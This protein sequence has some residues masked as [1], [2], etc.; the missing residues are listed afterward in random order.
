MGDGILVSAVYCI[1]LIELCSCVKQVVARLSRSSVYL[2]IL[3]VDVSCGWVVLAVDAQPQAVHLLEKQL[4][5]RQ[6]CL[7][8]ITVLQLGEL[9]YVDAPGVVSST[10][11]GAES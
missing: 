4:R 6:R 9:A 2:A 7:Q 10:R 5:V 8:V 3:L 11:A 1:I